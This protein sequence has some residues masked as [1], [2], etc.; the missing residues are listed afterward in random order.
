M[1]IT[2]A[3]ALLVRTE[4]GALRTIRSGTVRLAETAAE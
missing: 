4:A 1:G 3:G 2:P